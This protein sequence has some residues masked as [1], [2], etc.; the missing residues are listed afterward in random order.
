MQGGQLCPRRCGRLPSRFLL[1][2]PRVAF[3]LRVTLA[4]RIWLVLLFERDH[5][6][7]PEQLTRPP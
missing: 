7:R 5:V 1:V 4:V 2:G 6:F 3:C